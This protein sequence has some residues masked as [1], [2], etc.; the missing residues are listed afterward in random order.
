LARPDST[1]SG[2]TFP[3]RVATSLLHAIALP[4]LAT[5]SLEAYEPLALKLAR[6]T[7]LL[8]SI[9]EHLSKN[10][11]THPLFDTDGFRRKIEAAYTQMCAHRPNNGPTISL[12]WDVQL[13][14]RM[15]E[16]SFLLQ[17]LAQQFVIFWTAQKRGDGAVGENRTHDLSLTKGLR[18]HYATTATVV[19]S[20]LTAQ[21]LSQS[22]LKGA[23]L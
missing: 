6:D 18:Y 1:C 12:R 11:Q 19:F 4:E 7:S 10:R 3:G 5:D 14:A 9:R 2:K 15:F 13:C 8:Q 17:K 21:L 20:D 22:L 16:I 23:L